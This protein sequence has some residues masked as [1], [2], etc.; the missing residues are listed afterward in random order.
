MPI[1]KTTKKRKPARKRGVKG[2]PAPSLPSLAAVGAG[3]TLATGA[4]HVPRENLPWTYCASPIAVQCL[5]GRIVPRMAKA[6]MV[7]G[8]NGNGRH[9]DGGKGYL[10][11]L[12]SRGYV[13]IPH[14]FECIA[15]GEV[16]A[17]GSVE[18]STY[19]T[20]HRGQHAGHEVDYWTDAWVR[21]RLLGPMT[22]W[23][24]DPEGWADFLGRVM[25]L[26]HPGEI[27]PAQI[28]IAVDPLLRRAHQVM[29]AETPH[30]R[31]VLTQLLTHIPAEYVPDDLSD[32]YRRHHDRE[33]RDHS[34]KSAPE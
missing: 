33:Q 22:R 4:I 12:D 17:P 34:A 20:R 31:L 10:A 16:R 26:I 13:R 27:D 8:L 14:T 21:P 24:R 32:L 15:F 18:D 6:S 7:P 29:H 25:E 1:P 23:D 28:E 30:S 19:L 2:D 3:P 5:R 9:V 11:E